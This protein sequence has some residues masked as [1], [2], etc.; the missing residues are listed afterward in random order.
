MPNTKKS[1]H[2]IKS[3]QKKVPK[4][5]AIKLSQHETGNDDLEEWKKARQSVRPADQLPL[6]DLELKEEIVR[7]LTCTDPQQPTNLV[8]FNYAQG[9]FV[10][11]PVRGNTLVL[12][13][14]RGTT[15]HKESE[16]ARKQIA[17]L[18]F[19]M[20]ED[21]IP[22]ETEPELEQKIE[23]KEEDSEEQEDDVDEEGEDG[24]DAKHDADVD[25]K[26]EEEDDA[27]ASGPKKKL[28]NQFNYCERASLTYNNPNR[29]QETQ[30][31]PPPRA[32]FS[33][34]VLQWIIFDA[35]EEDYAAQQ[36]EKEKEKKVPI[37]HKKIMTKKKKSSEHNEAAQ[38]R[39]LIAWKTLERMVNLNTYDDI[40]KDYR[41]WEDPSDE[42]RDE[43]GTLLPLW[44]F[45]YE[46][47]KKTMITDIIWNPWYYD[48]FAV[49]FGALDFMY[50]M[51]GAVCLFTL[52][53][54][55]YPEHICMTDSGVMCVDIHP[56]YPFM[57]VVGLY[58][59]S[60]HIYNVCVNC[61]EPQYRSNSV[62]NKH[63]GIVWEVKWGPDLQDGEMNF[64]SV[65]A[66]GKINNWLLMQNELS[67]TTIITLMLDSDPVPGPDG[68]YIKLKGSATCMVFHPTNPLIFLVGT[69]EGYIYKCSTLYSSSYLFT[70]QA[71]HMP[72]YRLDYN[73][74]NS[75][76]FISS[77]G[78]W[79]VKIWEDDRPEPLFVFD[80][81]APIG[82]V[83]W[84]PYSSTVFGAVTSKGRVFVFDLNINK[85]K[86]ICR[87]NIVSKRKNRLT[88]L[89]FNVKLPIL[90]VGDDKGC[91]HTLKL[92]PNLRI[93][94]RAPKKQQHLD[95]FTLQCMKLD[96][97]LAL[98]REPQTISQPED[99]ETLA[100]S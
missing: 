95:Q 91:V 67:L 61:K 1:F 45:N 100:D 31:V 74:F 53:N 3:M 77:S 54:P 38:A 44:K 88:R 16:E 62:T 4:T 69:E 2:G 32:T 93:P 43:E 75:N 29:T 65:A 82:G 71:H 26:G 50:Q 23:E 24:E 83:K 86:A 36:K 22:D 79:R 14:I 60:V 48:L 87:Q 64:Y 19:E 33:A 39:L 78:D 96:K 52:K 28:T 13:N 9:R 76:I 35:Y 80:L 56:K 99:V 7:V 25:G 66:D 34:Q 6:S 11:K 49:C 94:C 55:S 85:Y 8:E 70:Y 81:G 58:D 57:I 84:A 30:T 41:Y 10:P 40:A 20:P 68:M 51:P 46:K 47:T 92:S 21:I 59:G 12:L 63:G 73:K 72:V 18:G 89:A 42:F 97:L 17:S 90:I 98:V 15:I 37:L 27:L 5:S